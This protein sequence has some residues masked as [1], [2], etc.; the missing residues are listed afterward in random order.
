MNFKAN[1]NEFTNNVILRYCQT[2]GFGD[3]KDIMWLYKSRRLHLYKTLRENDIDNNS[4]IIIMK[5]NF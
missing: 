1:K 4:L 2:I 3:L 5:V